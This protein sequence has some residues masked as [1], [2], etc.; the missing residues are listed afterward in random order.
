M[1]QLKVFHG[2]ENYG[3]QAGFLAKGLRE[4]GVKAI[5]VVNPD[6]FNRFADVVLLHGGNIFQKVFKHSY[7]WLRKIYWF[8]KYNTFHFYYGNTL[9]PW[10]IDLPFY[11]F[12]G[13]KII[14]HYLG[15][16][17]QGYKKSVDKYKWT[18]V[19][20][21]I[22]KD[23]SLLHDLKIEKRFAFESKYTDLQFVCAPCYSEFV[24]NSLVIPLAIDLNEYGFSELPMHDILVIMHAPTHRGNKGTDFIIEAIE[25]LISEGEPICFNLVENVTHDRL[26][27]D[28]KKADIF[29]D[30]IM[31]GWY[32]TASIEAMALGRPVICSIRKS[33]FEYID[34][35]PEIPM[36]HADPDFIYDSIKYLI[37]NRSKLP[38]IGKASRRFIEKV[39]DVRKVTTAL[40]KYY[41]NLS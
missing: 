7:N 6:K 12:F 35:G 5:S 19:K 16:D 21:Y 36:I 9:F 15:N 17:V 24:P 37:K 20:A 31:G 41:Q 29:I 8:F 10:Q 27:E 39:H 2:L 30:Q 3:T 34:Y 26:K 14:F 33:Y 11:R 1:K 25:K 13:K 23:D 28:Y 32:G 18:N 40:I 4:Q 22:N 38:E